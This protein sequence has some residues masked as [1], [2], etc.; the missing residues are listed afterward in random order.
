MI[1]APPKPPVIVSVSPG[2]D[3][4]LSMV[5]EWLTQ[6]GYTSETVRIK[7]DD[8]SVWGELK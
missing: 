6:E 5:R 8:K 4:A 7:K 1:V 2:D 3:I